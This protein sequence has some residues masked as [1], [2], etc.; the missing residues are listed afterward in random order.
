MK[1]TSLVCKKRG[2][3]YRPLTVDTPN[4]KGTTK[5]T[6]ETDYEIKFKSTSKLPYFT[7]H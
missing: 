2:M 5:V 6:T 3:K 7:T 4:P 1:A